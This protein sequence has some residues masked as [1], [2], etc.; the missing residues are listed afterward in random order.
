[1]CFWLLFF[2]FTSISTFQV[3]SR[4]SVLIISVTRY[5]YSNYQFFKSDWLSLTLQCTNKV[6]CHLSLKGIILVIHVS[7]HPGLNA[8]YSVKLYLICISHFD[9]E[10]TYEVNSPILYISC[11]K[12]HYGPTLFRDVVAKLSWTCHPSDVVNPAYFMFN[13]RKDRFTKGKTI[14]VIYTVSGT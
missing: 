8:N 6:A 2:G 9:S 10:R 14:S 11:N 13:K 7:A 3:V 1:M 12:A 5:L 4:P